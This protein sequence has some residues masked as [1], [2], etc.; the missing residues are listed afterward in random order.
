[1]F[2]RYHFGYPGFSVFTIK[3]NSFIY[4]FGN[5]FVGIMMGKEKNM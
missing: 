4:T 1:M 3:L 2:T 5:N